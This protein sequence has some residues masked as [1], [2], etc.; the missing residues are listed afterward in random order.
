MMGELEEIVTTAMNAHLE[1]SRVLA[2]PAATQA[3]AEAIRPL[4]DAL[5]AAKAIAI[6]E[7]ACG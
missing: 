1:A 2:E 6:W 3:A 5:V 7:T 4:V